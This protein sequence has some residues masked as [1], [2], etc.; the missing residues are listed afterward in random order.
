MNNAEIKIHAFGYFKVPA[1]MKRSRATM[2]NDD[3]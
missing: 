3:I 2:T 1:G